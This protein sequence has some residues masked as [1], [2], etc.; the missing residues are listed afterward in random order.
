MTSFIAVYRGLTVGQARLI[1]VSADPALVAD[2][3]SKMLEKTAR[4]EDKIINEIESGRRSALSLIVRE[5]KAGKDNL[6]EQSKRNGSKT[7]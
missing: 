2:V 6:N 7:E 4:D 3:S 5:A 1:A